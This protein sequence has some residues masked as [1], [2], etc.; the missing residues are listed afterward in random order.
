[1]VK[2]SYSE[3]PPGRAS[4]P[5]GVT[6]EPPK[7]DSEQVSVLE[8]SEAHSETA[9]A[10]AGCGV[11]SRVVSGGFADRSAIFSRDLTAL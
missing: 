3:A 7:L 5:R 9:E 6:C 2:V 1:M 8:R 11:T 4:G 10:R